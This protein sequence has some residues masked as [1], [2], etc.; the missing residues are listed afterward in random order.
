MTHVTSSKGEETFYTYRNT[1][2]AQDIPAVL[3]E[4]SYSAQGEL[5]GSG[6]VSIQASKELTGRPQTAGEFRFT[7]TD[8]NG[9]QVSQGTN[10][11]DGSIAFSG[12]SY[13][14]EKLWQ[15]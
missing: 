12:I 10:G 11:A 9:S 1:E 15:T 13:T 6:D 7:V 2:E 3:F 8:R 4:N 14:T 5:G